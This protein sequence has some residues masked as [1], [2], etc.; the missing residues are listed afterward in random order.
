VKR[1][2]TLGFTSILISKYK[3]IFGNKYDFLVVISKYRVISGNKCGFWVV[4][5]KYKAI[6][7]NKCDFLV[8]I[9]KYRFKFVLFFRDGRPPFIYKPLIFK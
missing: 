8:D 2:L 3:V 5:S 6:S 1:V 4:I 7:G 9:S